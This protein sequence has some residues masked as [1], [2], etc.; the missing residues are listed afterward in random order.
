[1]QNIWNLTSFD[2]FS[3]VNL[4]QDLYVLV[5]VLK[6]I[7][8]NSQSV[9]KKSKLLFSF[10]RSRSRSRPKTGRLRKPDL[11]R[12]E[13]QVPCRASCFEEQDELHPDDLKE[14]D[15]FILFFKI[16]QGKIASA[17]R[18]L[19]NFSPQTEATTFAFSFVFILLLLY[20]VG[21][22]SPTTAI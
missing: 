22:Q 9:L 4:N 8:D 15:E 5:H 7:L 6:R 21:F 2:V 11:N 12:K 3:K 16:S 14:K 13:G 19:I 1:M 10:T 20:R 18:N 17:T